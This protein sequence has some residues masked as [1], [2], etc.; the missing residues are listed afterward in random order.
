MIG[1]PAG[2]GKT[3]GMMWLESPAIELGVDPSRQAEAGMLQGLIMQAAGKIAMERFQD[4]A[5]MRS[6]VQNSRDKIIADTKIPPE[7]RP[8]LDQ[9]MMS[10]DGFMAKWQ[11]VQTVDRETAKVEGKQSPA[12][13]NAFE[14]ARIKT[15]DVTREPPKGSREAVFQ[16]IRSRWDISFPQAMLWGVLACAAT[17]AISIVQA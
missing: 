7:M 4:P 12:A 8:L 14:I 17:F 9:M 10:L 1:I 13:G 16:Q 5:S 15:I 2:F 11:E 6:L 3:A